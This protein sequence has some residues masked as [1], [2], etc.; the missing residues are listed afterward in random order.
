MKKTTF[1]AIILAAFFCFVFPCNLMSCASTGVPIPGKTN[2]EA[3]KL[4][5]EYLA[6]ADLYFGMEK[7]DKAIEYLIFSEQ[8]YAP[9]YSSVLNSDSENY[10]LTLGYL[11]A[12]NE[13]T[14][15][16]LYGKKFFSFYFPVY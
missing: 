10:L 5:N 1:T 13:N 8:Y 7:Y 15:E 16:N 4:S 9:K 11:S 2:A 12:C 14:E 6:I 3:K